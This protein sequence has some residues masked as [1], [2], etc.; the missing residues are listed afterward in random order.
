MNH[1]VED[2]KACLTAG[3][4]ASEVLSEWCLQRFGSGSLTAQVLEDRAVE[5]G[6]RHRR[7]ELRWQDIVVSSAEN[8]YLPR[9]LPAHVRHRMLETAVPFG[10]LLSS[11]GLV[12]RTTLARLLPG[13]DPF[14]LEIRAALALPKKGDVAFVHEFY[15]SALVE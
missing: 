1:S 6:R 4:T 2:L 7:V 12:R 10:T 9:G 14:V 13:A 3:S 15:H 11:A 5:N 8:I